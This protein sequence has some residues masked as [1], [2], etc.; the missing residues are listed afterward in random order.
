MGWGAYIILI[1]FAAFVLLLVV[2]PN[3]SCFGKRIRS[4]FYPLRRKRAMKRK[5]TDYK[6]DLGGRPAK[7]ARAG[8]AP[9]AAATQAKDKKTED[10]GFRLD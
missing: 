1:I 4:P 5:L 10:Y 3:M 2:N 8:A 7:D 6:F 9:G